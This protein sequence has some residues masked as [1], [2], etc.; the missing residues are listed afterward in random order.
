MTLDQ[1]AIKHDTDK[2]SKHHGYTKYYERHFEPVRHEP[3]SVMEVGYGG[4]NFPDRGGGGARMWLDYF[5]SAKIISVDL[6]KKTNLPINDRYFFYK[7]SQDDREGLTGVSQIFG[8][9]DIVIDDAS[10]ICNLTLSTFDILFPLVKLGGWYVIEDIEGSFFE[11]W[12]KGTL[13][14]N[15]FQFPS[16]VNLGRRLINDVNCKYMPNYTPTHQIEEIHFYSNIIF[17][18][19]KA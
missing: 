5:T 9:F 8:G 15:D 6:Y 3:V 19:K 18:K 14:H 13:D 1:L 17:I 2:S 10:H 16:P 4:Y 11:G 7:L 12:S